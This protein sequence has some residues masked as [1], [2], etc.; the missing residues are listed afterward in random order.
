MKELEDEVRRNEIP[1]PRYRVY[2]I[3]AA[4][5]T[6]LVWSEVLEYGLEPLHDQNGNK[7]GKR[8]QVY[9]TSEGFGYQVSQ[10]RK[11]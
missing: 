6:P 1:L 9:I 2:S 7:L 5:G 8:Y 3:R 11:R 10:S 4:F